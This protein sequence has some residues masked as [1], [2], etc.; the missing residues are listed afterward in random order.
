MI[1]R[2]KVLLILRW[3]NIDWSSMREHISLI[4][5]LFSYLL[6]VLIELLLHFIFA[7][8]S[9]RAH[10][11]KSLRLNEVTGFKIISTRLRGSQL[12]TVYLRSWIVPRELRR[13]SLGKSRAILLQQRDFVWILATLTKIILRNKTGQPVTLVFCARVARGCDVVVITR[14]VCEVTWG[15]TLHLVLFKPLII[16]RLRLEILKPDLLLRWRGLNDIE[17]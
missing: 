15:N 5:T 8:L 9:C 14:C 10:I 1:D 16:R 12:E 13:Y 7:A 17:A 11:V 3:K 2:F 4:L 6:R